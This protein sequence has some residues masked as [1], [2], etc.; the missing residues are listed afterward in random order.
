MRHIE[1]RKTHNKCKK[2]HSWIHVEIERMLPHLIFLTLTQPSDLYIRFLLPCQRLRAKQSISCLCCIDDGF[3]LNS[4]NIMSLLLFHGIAFSEFKEYAIVS[5]LLLVHEL[6]F[7]MNC[8][9]LSLFSCYVTVTLYLN[10]P[11]RSRELQKNDSS[12]PSL[13]HLNLTQGR[14]KRTILEPSRA[15]SEPHHCP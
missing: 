4:Y 3:F 15:V 5:V 6:S 8:G 14:H 2:I 1:W 13:I 9:L 12:H 11:W 7:S 10:T